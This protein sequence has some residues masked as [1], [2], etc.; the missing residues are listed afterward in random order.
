MKVVLL[1]VSPKTDSPAA[2]RYAIERAAALEAELIVVAVLD[3]ALSERVGRRLEES[4]F[5]GEK[6]SE[7]VRCCLERDLRAQGETLAEAIAAEAMGAGVR[8][9]TRV[10]EGDL[11]DVAGRC[12]SG[13]E[14]LV[15]VVA[16]EKRSW[17]GR[18]FESP[19]E[20]QRL[21]RLP[22]CEV[23]VIEG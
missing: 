9:R 18:L 10:E 17:L 14:V 6:V 21:L 3:P 5:V 7:S 15:A 23:K 16:A 12:C 8:A 19:G 4:G 20:T 13:H 1:F 11:T 22:R 2:R